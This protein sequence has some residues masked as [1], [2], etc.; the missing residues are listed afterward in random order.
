MSKLRSIYKGLNTWDKAL[1]PEM[2]QI[3]KE[4]E[5]EVKNGENL[6]SDLLFSQDSSNIIN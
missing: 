3:V 1:N 5:E 6:T 4:K 2:D